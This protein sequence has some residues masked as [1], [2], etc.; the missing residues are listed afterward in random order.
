MAR[1]LTCQYKDYH[2]MGFAYNEPHSSMARQLTGQYERFPLSQTL[3]Y[4]RQSKHRTT[5]STAVSR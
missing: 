2:Y 4:G 1:Q 3:T 5:Y